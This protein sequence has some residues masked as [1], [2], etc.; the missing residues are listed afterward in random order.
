MAQLWMF[1]LRS[2]WPENKKLKAF[3]WNFYAK[4]L[5]CNK[6]IVYTGH[7]VKSLTK[8][9]SQGAGGSWP[10]GIN[11]AP[12]APNEITLVQSCHFESQSAPLLTPE[13]PL[14]SPHFEKSG[15][16][17]A[18]T[19]HIR[20]A[21]CTINQDS[22]N[23]A[24]TMI[25]NWYSKLFFYWNN[26]E[27]SVENLGF[28]RQIRFINR[29]SKFLADNPRF[30]TRHFKFFNSI[31]HD[32]DLLPIWREYRFINRYIPSFSLIIQDFQI[33]IPSIST[34][35]SKIFLSTAHLTGESRYIDW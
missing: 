7:F 3:L 29:Y 2:P 27:I 33:N 13:P 31:F 15:Y 34:R 12:L 14:L 8:W 25:L 4:P 32:F 18:L 17:P 23:N 9:C 24:D 19:G 10:P 30:S 5:S 35:Y 11:S 20:Q 16:A 6:M 22:K 1:K 26:N 28:S 21:F